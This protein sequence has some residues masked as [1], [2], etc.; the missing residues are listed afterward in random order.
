MRHALV[1]VA[2][3]VDLFDFGQP[4]P[5]AVAQH[6]DALVLGAHFFAGQTERFAHADDLM[7]GQRARAE[8]ALMA[9]AMHLRFDADT[10]L[11]AHIQRTDALRAVRLV[12]RERHQVDLQ[13]LQID[14]HLAGRLS[15]VHMEDDALFAADFAQRFHVLD[16][17]DFV[18]HHHHRHEH[19]VGTQRSLEDI[20]VDQAVVLDVQVRDFKALA[21]QFTTGVEHSLVLGLD[22]DD[23]L[24]A[25]GVEVGCALDGQVVGFGGAGGPDDFARVGID[26]LGDFFAGA[27][28][29]LFGLPA[30]RVAARGRVAKVLVQPGHHGVD[31]TGV[32]R[33]RG[34]IIQ[35]DRTG[36]HFY[37]S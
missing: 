15:G 5:E 24:A 16:H 34:R 3:E 8:T 4:L 7:R 12:G 21:F 13:L 25:F 23:V 35:I 27:F 31:D 32:D 18:V 1:H 36:G 6:A 19:G 28:D 9:T 37:N 10:R 20:Q 33:R 2:V 11:A 14:F 22:R 26:Q 17:A 30:K 29:G